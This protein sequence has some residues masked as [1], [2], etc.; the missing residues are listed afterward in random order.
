M[1]K[2]V[3]KE[4]TFEIGK[5]IVLNKDDFEKNIKTVVSKAQLFININKSQPLFNYDKLKIQKLT[6]IKR[7]MGFMN[8]LLKDW[9]IIISNNRKSSSKIIDGEKTTI[10]INSYKL[11][12]IDEIDKYI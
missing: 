1:I 5:D 3:F 4:L 12:Y 9:G 2:E 10:N 11:K 7:F 8:A 6:S